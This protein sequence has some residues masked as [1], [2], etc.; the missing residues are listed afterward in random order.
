MKRLFFLIAG[1]LMLASLTAWA[2]G[3]QDATD[4]DGE[5][6]QTVQ[7]NFTTG[8]M[9]GGFYAI[10]GGIAD[11]VSKNVDNIYLTAVTSGGVNENINRLH[12]A[13]AE[14][15]M[16]NNTDPPLAFAGE[17]PYNQKFD[18]MRGVGILYMQY[19]EVYTLERTGIKTFSDLKDRVVCVGSPGGSMHKTLFDIVK[20]HGLDP[21]KDFKKSVYL[22][23]REAME[24]LKLGQV[25][26]VMEISTL[27]TPALSELALTEDVRI[28]KFDPGIRAKLVEEMPKYLLLTI[29]DGA[30]QGVGEVDTIGS[31][32]MWGC[33]KDLPDDLVYEAVKAVYS[34]AGLKYLSQVHPAGAGISLETAAKFKPIP[35]HP[36]AEKFY[37]EAGVFE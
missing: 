30:Y 2:G 26:A 18:N 28:V 11:F 21:E 37:R 3:Q 34:D 17:A 20:V 35:V 10:G 13:N 25:E 23:A 5:K 36:G 6:Q 31:A 16:L 24:A 29:P 4:A 19:V 1:F 9:G 8:S 33:N 27:P 32:A 14:F 12:S 7:W 22:P 15:G